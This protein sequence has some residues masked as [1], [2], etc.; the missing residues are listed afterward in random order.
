MDELA[1]TAGP[2]KAKSNRH[3]G[4]L[5]AE[6]TFR[7]YS[8]MWLALPPRISTARSEHADPARKARGPPDIMQRDF[9]DS[10]RWS[11]NDVAAQELR[12]DR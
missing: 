2:S 6:D 9:S 8:L 5:D 11:C 10:P 3:S 7:A 4:N 12:N 1:L